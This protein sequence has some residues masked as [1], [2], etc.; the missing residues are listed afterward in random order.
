MKEP[1][2]ADRDETLHAFK[3]K[4]SKT[5]TA[6][7]QVIKESDHAVAL[8][9]TMFGPGYPSSNCG[10]KVVITYKGKSITATV[11]DVAPG[12]SRYGLDRTPGAFKALAPLDKHKIDVTWHYAK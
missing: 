9:P 8:D 10:R 11:L 6:S 1:S 2:T 3:G 5:T 7:P 4:P 12:A